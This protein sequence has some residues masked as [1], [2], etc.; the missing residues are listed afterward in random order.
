MTQI[1]LSFCMMNV[2]SMQKLQSQDLPQFN[3]AMSAM[4]Q[5]PEG[6]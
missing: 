1:N 4:N 2:F 6:V 3:E 5:K